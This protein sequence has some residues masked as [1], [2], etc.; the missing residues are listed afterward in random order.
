MTARL[1]FAAA[2]LLAMPAAASAQL[3]F[4]TDDADVTARGVVHVE[5]FNEYDW[6]P[7]SQAPH[8]RQ[9]TVNVKLNVGLGHNLELDLDAPLI[10]I[11]NDTTAMP[12]NPFGLGDTNLGVKYRL[13]DE[14]DGA[15]VPALAAVFYLETPTGDSTTGLGSG[16]VDS[17][18]YLAA[19]KT[20]TD[21]LVLHVN[22]GYLFTGNT[23]TGVVGLAARGHVATMGGSL[24]RKMSETVSLGVEV[25]A[26]ATSNTDLGRTQLQMMLGGSYGVK[27]N[28]SLDAGVIV[29][30]FTASPRVG[31]LV[32]FSA[33]F[34]A[35][36][37]KA[38]HQLH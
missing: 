11:V 24:V 17:W 29:G 22:G 18:L 1:L 7:S 8:L 37:P 5:S 4:Y 20:I 10:T 30:R 14:H 9:N 3:P 31:V 15:A 16:L 35:F 28:L 36:G 23:S 25:T 34:P 21:R 38:V 13:R 12:R 19:Q 26:A 27:E 32:G 33:D 2:L 6:L